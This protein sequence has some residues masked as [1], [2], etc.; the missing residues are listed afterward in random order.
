V[1]PRPFTLLL[2]VSFATVSPILEAQKTEVSV[3]Y[4]LVVYNP[5]KSL[6]GER[7]FNGGGGS[8][9]RNFGT[10][11][12]LKGEFEGYAT[13]TFT[14][15]PVVAPANMTSTRNVQMNPAAAAA[16]GTIN[17]QANMFT[18]LFGPQFN[19]PIHKSRLFGETLFGGAHTNGYANFFAADG[20]T[21]LHPTNDG[22]SMAI[23]GG[24]DFRIA[25]HV[26]VRPAQL[27]YFLTRYEWKQL[28]INNQSNFRYQG[29][30][31]F[32]F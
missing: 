25:D 24:L 19:L 22:F 2:F 3:N 28:G 6:A 26:A 10:F 29:G 1:K 11:F 27:D 5:A 31:V 12:T 9:G 7:N 4:S 32:V 17:T 30:A 8:V 16:T 20:L 21:S 13:T 15:H 14:W 23:G 18:Y